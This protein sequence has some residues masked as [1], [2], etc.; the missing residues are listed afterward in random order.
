MASVV[1]LRFRGIAIARCAAG[2]TGIVL[3][4]RRWQLV[5]GLTQIMEA[6]APIFI[7]QPGPA[8]IE[9]L[10]LQIAHRQLLRIPRTMTLADRMHQAGDPVAGFGGC[11]AFVL[12]C[13][14]A[15]W[16]L[17]ELSA[18]FDMGTAGKQPG[19][20]RFGW[21]WCG[22]SGKNWLGRV[23]QGVAVAV[24]HGELGGGKWKNLVQ[25]GEAEVGI[26][27]Q[28]IGKKRIP[29]STRIIFAATY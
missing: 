22:G 8:A 11:R 20:G 3:D 1:A 19:W 17:G 15:L 25:V 18:R 27:L 26:A 5:D 12:G 24:P 10:T 9:E 16:L 6:D 2:H 7:L 4:W 21:R 23:E 28:C 14:L 13:D 29:F